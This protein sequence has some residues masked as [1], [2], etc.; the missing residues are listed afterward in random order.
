MKEFGLKEL[1]GW[2]Q[3]HIVFL[4]VYV[5]ENHVKLGGGAY[6][7]IHYVPVGI[8]DDRLELVVL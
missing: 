6:L 3:V 2:A 7:E 1:A 5:H 4:V 8:C